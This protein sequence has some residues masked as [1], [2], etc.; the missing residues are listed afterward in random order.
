MVKKHKQQN[1]MAGAMS[2]LDRPPKTTGSEIVAAALVFAAF[3][4]VL[5]ALSLAAQGAS[6]E[7]RDASPTAPAFNL[8]QQTRAPRLTT[9]ASSSAHPA[10]CRIQNTRGGSLELGSGTLIEKNAD[11]SRGVVLTCSHLFSDG[12]G[13]VIVAFPDGTTHGARLLGIDR[14]ADL[15]A[16]LIANPV[17]EPVEVAAEIVA[18]S[19]LSV[20][21]YGPVGV[22]RCIAG[23]LLGQS[24]SR[25]QESLMVDGAVRLG[26]SG[27]AVMDSRGRLVAVV[28]GEAGGVTYASYGRPLQRFLAKILGRSG[29]SAPDATPVSPVACP[30]GSC[31]LQW[32]PSRQNET[33]KFRFPNSN[34]AMQ[35]RLDALARQIELLKS[36]KQDRGDFLTRGDLSGLASQQDVERVESESATRHQSLLSRI[37]ALAQ[38]M[39]GRGIADRGPSGAS[40]GRAA[41]VAT[42]GLLGLSGPAGWAVIAAAAIGGGII[43]RRMKRRLRGAGGRRRRRFR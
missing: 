13:R 20:C 7:A 1:E 22:Y 4:V 3:L 11:G 37:G 43:G 10:V 40:L 14:E 24:Q 15:A 42:V 5:I 32:S 16:L 31:P 23:R 6:W 17:A 25:G 26:D 18:G 33:P 36:R 28:W 38:S 12:V 9:R 30:D 2:S 39:A 29:R 35:Q 8:P 19:R 41:G 34:A 21:G 27:G